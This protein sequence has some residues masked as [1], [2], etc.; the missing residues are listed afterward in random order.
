MNNT[1]YDFKPYLLTAEHCA[2]INTF[3]S[4]SNLNDWVFYFN[5]AS[6]TCENPSN[7]NG[8]VD[9]FVVGSSLVARSDDNGGDLGSDFLLLE[10]NNQVPE[11]FDAYYAGFN[12]SQINPISGVCYHHPAGDIKKV[13]TYNQGATLGSFGEV[14]PN[15]HWVLRWSATANG[16]GTTEGGSS[17]SSLLDENGRVLGILTGGASSC[18]EPQFSD[19][20]GTIAYGWRSNGSSS[21][22]QLAPWLDPLNVGLLALNG[23]YFGEE[24]PEYAN[25]GKLTIAPN[26]VVNGEITLF[27]LASLG[28]FVSLQVFDISGRLVFESE[29]TPSASEPTVFQLKQ[30]Q[31][32]LYFARLKQGNSTQ[33]QKIWLQ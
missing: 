27:S 1:A 2:I 20:Y 21:L 16:F 19:L 33:T 30:Y 17:G 14:T 4:A 5:Y 18:S 10:L 25:L 7:E 3:A 26:P 23:A 8:L 28:Q 32:G 15:T 13:S 24:R 9:D 11:S 29:K 6:A 31:T 12:R 22:N